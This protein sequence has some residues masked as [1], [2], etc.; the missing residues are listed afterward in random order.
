MNNSKQRLEGI[1]ESL[2]ATAASNGVITRDC[3]K[4]DRGFYSR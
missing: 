2:K 3:D 4:G 1:R